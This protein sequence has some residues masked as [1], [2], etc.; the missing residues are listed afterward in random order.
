MGLSLD[1]E[2]KNEVAEKRARNYKVQDDSAR[3]S[4]AI[5]RRKTQR[6]P[7]QQVVVEL[8]TTYSVPPEMSEEDDYPIPYLIHTVSVPPNQVQPFSQ[9][10]PADSGDWLSTTVAR[11]TS[12][13]P[14]EIALASL[15]VE[16]F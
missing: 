9:C 14:E 11:T 8:A 16:I 7:P 12:F 2:K 15:P 10:I 13:T 1:P 6:D 3:C 4:S 5:R